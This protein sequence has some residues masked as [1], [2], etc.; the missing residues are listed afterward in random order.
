MR[1]KLL[2]LVHLQEGQA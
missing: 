2:F 1:T